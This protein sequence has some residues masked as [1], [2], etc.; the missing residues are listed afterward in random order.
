MILL[1][2]AIISGFVFRTARDQDAAQYNEGY[3]VAGSCFVCDAM[4]VLCSLL[5]AVSVD[6]QPARTELGEAP[7]TIGRW[8]QCTVV[9]PHTTVSRRHAVIEPSGPR[10]LLIDSG[11]SNGTYV[12]GQKIQTSH[13]LNDQDLIGL[14]T[15]L[16]VLQFNDPDPTRKTVGSL[17]YNPEL[18]TFFVANR[19]LDLPQLEF[20]LLLHLYE[21][22]GKICTRESLTRAAW[23]DPYD[24]TR[25]G[26]ALDRKLSDL[27]VKL[28]AAAH[29][30]EFIQLLRGRGYILSP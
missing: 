3:L 16:G 19:R 28:R 12:N 2:S 30:V 20:R 18:M 4:P 10:Y 11:S 5:V 14:G 6:V 13:L 9:V 7:C 29:D 23:G 25:E 26:D 8:P 21:H 27:R 1:H 15:P 22:A 17:R 24:P